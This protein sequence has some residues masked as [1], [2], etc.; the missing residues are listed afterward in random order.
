MYIDIHRNGSNWTILHRSQSVDCSGG[1]HS[2]QT[3]VSRWVYTHVYWRAGR[4]LGRGCTAPNLIG[5]DGL[6]FRLVKTHSRLR[7][8]ETAVASSDGGGGVAM[9]AASEAA[10]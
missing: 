5:V 4:S 3:S 6:L 10:E 9:E 1:T 8:V 7:P 2:I